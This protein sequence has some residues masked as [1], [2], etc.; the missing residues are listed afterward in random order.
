MRRHLEVIASQLRSCK[1]IFNDSDFEDFLWKY[2]IEVATFQGIRVTGKQK[3]YLEYLMNQKA[4]DMLKKAEFFYVILDSPIS[5]KEFNTN[6][7]ISEMVRR[8]H[9]YGVTEPACHPLYKSLK[10]PSS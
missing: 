10:T 4:E 6:Q 7:E 9:M 5:M 2:S 1:L 8:E 3:G